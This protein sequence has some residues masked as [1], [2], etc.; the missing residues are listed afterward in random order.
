M[1]FRRKTAVGLGVV[2]LLNLYFAA[3]NDR[4]LIIK[5]FGAQF[6]K[7][8]ATVFYL[9]VGLACS[10]PAVH[11]ALAWW[12]NKRHPQ[13]ITMDEEAIWISANPTGYHK[14]NLSDIISLTDKL[15][16]HEH[17]SHREALHGDAIKPRGLVICTVHG[18]FRIVYLGLSPTDYEEIKT[19]LELH[20]GT[21]IA[22]VMA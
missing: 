10:L 6:D 21:T 2:G 4:G 16:P 15:S 17:R 22:K 20:F 18:E 5:N 9:F 19:R 8:G 13:S 12:R 7:D 11:F 14:I 3:T 1:Y